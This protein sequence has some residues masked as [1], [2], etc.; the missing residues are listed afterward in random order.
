MN[1]TSTERFFAKGKK[2]MDG[3]ILDL[4]T[5][6]FK[7]LIPGPIE[8]AWDYLTKPELLKTWFANVSLEP[9]V[10]GAVVVHFG[11]GDH[12]CDTGGIR[13]TV[14]EFREPHVIAFTWFQQRLQPDGSRKS[15][16]EGAV[17]FE[18]AERGDKVL[19]TLLHT[20]L[21]LHELANH[22]AGWNAYLDNLD[23]LMSGR[24][25]IDFMAVFQELHPRY[26]ERIAA[27][28]RAGAA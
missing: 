23:S 3:S 13:G 12:T 21:P 9:C 26:A 22:S 10:G 1:T 2:A 25:T 27:L 18:L 16:D 17:R 8:L 28:Q 20:G 19:L 11:D 15:S 6:E 14:R 4:H 7:R 24:G 5:V